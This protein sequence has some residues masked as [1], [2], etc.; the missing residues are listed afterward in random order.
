MRPEK[1]KK[2]SSLP[3]GHSKVRCGVGSGSGRVVVMSVD[4]GDQRGSDG[5]KFIMWLWISGRIFT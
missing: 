4:R 2:I 3:G 5:T 1:K